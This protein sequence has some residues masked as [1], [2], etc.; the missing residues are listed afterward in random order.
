MGKQQNDNDDLFQDMNI[1]G[2]ESALLEVDKPETNELENELEDVDDEEQGKGGKGEPPKGPKAGK[3]KDKPGG[4]PKDDTFIVDDKNEGNKGPDDDEEEGKDKK[5]GKDKKGGGAPENIEGNESPVYLHAAALQEQGVLPNFDLKSLEGLEPADAIVKINEHIQTQIEASIE[6]GVE[7][8]KS[9]IGDKAVKFIEDLEKGVPFESLAE[10]YSLEERYAS[11]T[12]KALEAD[13][14]LQEQVYADL[15][16]IKGF[17]EPKIKKM[18]EMAKEKDILLE[19]STDGLKEI[20]KTIDDDRKQ[21]RL[22]AEAE[23][24]AKD[25]RN[26]ATKIAIENTVKSTKEI[27]PGIELNEDE[28]KELIKMVTVPVTF[29][30]KN[31]KKIPMSAAMA[32]RAKNPI[33]FELKLAYLIKNGF[34]DEKIKD[35]AF[36]IFTKKVET[37]ATKRL[38]EIMSGEKKTTGKPSSEVQKSKK[39]EDEDKSD[40]VFPQELY[41]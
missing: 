19:E 17:S 5:A 20:Q 28:K 6:E 29:T 12:A 2:F 16:T 13:P 41:K 24:K 22:D 40:F 14:E 34:F 37:S 3:E 39:K 38:A 35:G 23:K 1:S 30:D 8:Y 32:Q 31:G 18:V 10:N 26:K 7:E 15:L 9:T 4:K 27:L 11:I 25:D 36:N 21:L 33:A